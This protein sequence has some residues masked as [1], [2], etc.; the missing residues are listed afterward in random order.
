MLLF[1]SFLCNAVSCNK[2]G[3]VL[4]WSS[5]AQSFDLATTS[6]TFSHLKFV[7]PVVIVSWETGMWNGSR[8]ELHS[9]P[10]NQN[11][12]CGRVGGGWHSFFVRLLLMF[13]SFLASCDKAKEVFDHDEAVLADFLKC[14][15]FYKFCSAGREIFCHLKLLNRLRGLLEMLSCSKLSYQ[16]THEDE[17]SVLYVTLGQSELVLFILWEA[18]R[19]IDVNWMM[20]NRMGNQNRRQS[21]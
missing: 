6:A 7:V 11:D 1:S 4:L 2:A 15:I 21:N 19:L 10:P 13:L 12:E 3:V 17:N 8:Q 20:C 14:T 5:H 9:P 18:A 16:I